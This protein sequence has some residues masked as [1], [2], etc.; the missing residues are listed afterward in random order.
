MN[1]QTGASDAD[2]LATGFRQVDEQ[3][4]LEKFQACLSFMERLEC[5]RA[6]KAEVLRRLELRPGHRV[7]DVGCGLGFDV[8]KIADIVGAGGQVVGLDRSAHLL[9]TATERTGA[10]RPGARFVVGDAHEL[11]FDDEAFDACRIDRTLQHLEDPPRVLQELYRV[12]RRG[13]RLVCAE[14]DWGTL[15]IASQDR[16]TVRRVVETWGD[17]FRQGWIGRELL[18]LVQRLR[19]TDVTLSGHL[20][21]AEGFSAADTVFDISRTVELLSKEENTPRYR[22]WLAD[23]RHSDTSCPILATVTLFLISGRKD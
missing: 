16:H 6:Y 9:S 11:D 23:L 7:L 20:L 10:N 14:P 4:N 12:L 18:G 17:Q 3:A 21:V 2:Y 22:D 8:D 19:L 15:T 5:F 1:S 13:G